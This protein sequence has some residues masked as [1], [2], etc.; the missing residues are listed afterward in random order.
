MSGE[1]PA[2]AGRSGERPE[3]AFGLHCRL[4]APAAQ[5]TTHSRPAAFQRLS[6]FR[7]R[8]LRLVRL[9]ARTNPGQPQLHHRARRR[10]RSRRRLA[11]SLRRGVLG[12]ESSRPV[13]HS[14]QEPAHSTSLRRQAQSAGVR[15][16]LH[17][18]FCWGGSRI[19]GPIQDRDLRHPVAV[20]CTISL[21]RYAASR[22]ERIV[23]LR[24]TPQQVLAGGDGRVA[25]RVAFPAARRQAVHAAV[26]G[27]LEEERDG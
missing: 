12:V 23:R 22:L 10:S 13:L 8:P 17:P 9:C 15:Q 2:G 24:I 27:G 25:R 14:E 18:H 21:F 1:R 19:Q 11:A 26:E 20:N 16:L 5:Q 6:A 3:L 4:P 7:L